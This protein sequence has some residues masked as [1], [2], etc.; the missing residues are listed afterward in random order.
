MDLIVSED[1]NGGTAI[2]TTDSPASHY[3]MPVLQITAEDI[4][5]D[6]GP[7]DLINL[8]EMLMSAG[9]IVYTWA[10]ELGRTHEE[11]QAARKFLSQWPEGPQI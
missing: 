3:G 9:E 5:G 11:M 7:G 1:M 2:L 6:F 4:D 8:G 10:M